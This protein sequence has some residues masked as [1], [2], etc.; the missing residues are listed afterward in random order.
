MVQPP[1][2]H[3]QYG[4]NQDLMWLYSSP[5]I[6]ER[7]QGDVLHF[8]RAEYWLES[9]ELEPHYRHALKQVIAINK[10]RAK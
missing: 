7:T 5:D 8:C 10:N 9:K 1:T 3:P 6:D 2:N 4:I